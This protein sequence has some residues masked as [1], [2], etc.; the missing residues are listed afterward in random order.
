MYAYSHTSALQTV[1]S[2]EIN[3]HRRTAPPS[4]SEFTRLLHT[5]EPNSPTVSLPFLPLFPF[6]HLSGTT[7][8]K[9]KFQS[10][11]ASHPPSEKPP[12]HLPKTILST[13]HLTFVSPRQSPQA[14][15]QMSGILNRNHRFWLCDCKQR[16][17]YNFPNTPLPT[18]HLT[19]VSTL[20]HSLL[21]AL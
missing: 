3:S 6:C 15:L 19:I 2:E 7:N 12:K 1:S 20:P 16:P 9:H 11:G 4:D 18:H 17:H 21:V 5:T 8:R 10:F 14:T 13:H